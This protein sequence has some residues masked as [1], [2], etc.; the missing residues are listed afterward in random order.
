MDPPI[1]PLWKL[2]PMGGGLNIF[3]GGPKIFKILANE[4]GGRWK[5]W[6]GVGRGEWSLT[7]LNSIL[8]TSQ[9]RPYHRLLHKVT[10]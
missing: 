5:P 1:P 6:C 4:E 3:R 9:F 8:G 2:I 7:G 10:I